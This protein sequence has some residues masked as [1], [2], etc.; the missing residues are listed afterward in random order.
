MSDCVGE[1]ISVNSDGNQKRVVRVSNFDMTINAKT[2]KTVITGFLKAD[3]SGTMT[4]SRSGNIL[5]S[6][7]FGSEEI[8]DA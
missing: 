6:F 3:G 8:K 4:V 1:I 7:T 5:N 2:M